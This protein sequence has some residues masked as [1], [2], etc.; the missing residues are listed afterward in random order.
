MKFLR[1]RIGKVEK[2]GI[3]VDDKIKEITG[4]FFNEFSVTENEYDMDDVK[5]LPPILPSKLVCIGRN[6]AD[7]AKELG[8]DVPETP[9]MFLKP[10]TTVI[11]D[12]DV[13]EYPDCS[14][15]VDHEAELGVVI[16]RTC[17]KV[18]EKDAMNYVLGYTCVNDITARDIQKKE[19]KFTRAKGFDTFAPIGPIIETEL[20]PSGVNV[21]C[22]VNGEVRQDGNTRDMIFNVPQ[23][24]SF[25][26]NVMTLL[27]GDIIATGT[28]AGVGALSVG[29][30]V[31]IE[32][33]GIGTLN[34]IVSKA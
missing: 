20:D 17:K 5:M 14:D 15:R 30:I 31:E 12:G 21:K 23:L 2:K 9:L 7:H 19:N 22:F 32:V 4:S 18:T 13:I 24:I 34:N 3:L 8:N 25:I 28:P 26:S 11:G 10:S 33:E 27:P 29:D 6:Y 1:F 16:K